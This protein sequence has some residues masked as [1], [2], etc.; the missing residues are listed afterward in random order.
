MTIQEYSDNLQNLYGLLN[1]DLADHTIVPASSE[2]LSAIKLRIFERGNNTANA[3][4]GNYSTKPLYASKQ[5]FIKGGAFIPQGKNKISKGI[6]KGD[7]IVPSIR[8]I[9]TGV[10]KNP[11]KYKRYTIVKSN[12]DTRKSMYLQEGYKELRTIQGLQVS[13]VNQNYSGNLKDSYQTQKIGLEVVLGLT[14]ELSSLK[15]KGQ[16]K[17]FG[18]IFSP[19]ALEIEAYN[20][21]VNYLIGRSIIMVLKGGDIVNMNENLLQNYNVEATIS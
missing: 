6:T 17:K 16:E 1:G 10:K 7:K 8:L 18:T 19:T 11:T 4:I 12:G 21:T 3:P 5:A 14:T 9:K 2:L 20:K 15:R 13:V